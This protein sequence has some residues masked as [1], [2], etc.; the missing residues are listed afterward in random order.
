MN[1]KKSQVDWPVFGL[2]GGLLLVFVI[3][4]AI[5]M[6][7]VTSFVNSSFALSVKWFGAFWQ[8]LLLATFIIA[9]PLAFSRYG[10]VKLG[11]LDQ[12]EFGT[13]K[14]ISMIMCTLLAGG[15]VFWAAAEPM[16]HFTSPPPLFGGIQAGTNQ[17]VNPALSQAFM[18]WGFLAWAILGTLSVVVMMYAHYHKGMP[19]KPRSLLYPIFGEKLMSKSLLG[20]A[21]DAFSILAVV[22][23]TIGPIG[24]LGLQASF[25]MKEILGIPDTFTTQLYIIIAVVAISAISAA[26][27]LHKG[28]EFLSN[29]NVVLAILLMAAILILGP[30]EFIVNAFISSFGMYIQEF[31]AMSTFRG[32]PEWLGWWTVFFWCWFLGYGPMMAIFISCISRGR[33]IREI[34]TAVAVISPIVTC[35]WFTVLGGSGIS[36]ELLNPGSISG[37][38]NEFG[39]PA[40]MISITKQLPLSYIMGPAFLILTILFV[41]TTSDS[42]AYTIS[43]A[44]TGN[45]NPSVGMRIFWALMM[46][47][48]A[49]ILLSIGNG[50]I[51]AL[52]SFIVVTAVPV[53][54]ILLPVCWLAPKVANEMAKEQGIVEEENLQEKVS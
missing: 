32:D 22:A 26:T 44:V 9:I 23:G 30:G 20:T 17:A 14:W 13:F 48:V 28:I 3:A 33:T 54:L 36:F 2:S 11:K 38:L 37:P 4:A 41:V 35:F 53:S 6:D 34:I 12:P 21:V 51:N 45:N 42:M 39:L 24:F 15:G 1:N 43:A 50:G 47:A 10:K 18:H 40:A 31:F 49:A 46:G 25:G 29:L 5:S 19:L 52:Q 7:A 8:V 16:F 27:G